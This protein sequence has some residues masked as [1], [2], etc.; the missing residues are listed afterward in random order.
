M[1][2]MMAKWR[3]PAQ[4]FPKWTQGVMVV[5]A[6]EQ[7]NKVDHTSRKDKPTMGILAI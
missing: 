3:N 7:R 6:K 1:G 4:S 5:P 2:K